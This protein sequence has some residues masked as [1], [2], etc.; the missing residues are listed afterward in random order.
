[1]R[2]IP[3]IICVSPK[4]HYQCLY[5]RQTD[6]RIGTH[7]GDSHVKMKAENGIMPP[8]MQKEARNRFSPNIPRRSMVLHD[9][10]LLDS[11][12]ARE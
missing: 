12:I 11:K 8:R 5:K 3:Q 7:G 10:G 1:M 6:V 4:I 9:F 2:K